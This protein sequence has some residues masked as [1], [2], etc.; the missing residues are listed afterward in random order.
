[1]P[2]IEIA[3]LV[4]TVGT[5]R[6]LAVVSKAHEQSIQAILRRLDDLERKIDALMAE[7]KDPPP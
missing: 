4:T 5:V 6:D 7:S 2:K 3:E 1:M